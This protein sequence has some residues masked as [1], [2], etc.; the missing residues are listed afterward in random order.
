MV[1]LFVSL[2]CCEGLFS[3]F[4]CNDKRNTCVAFTD[5][6]GN[7]LKHAFSSGSTG[8]GE[9]VVAILGDTTRIVS[10]DPKPVGV[11][12]SHTLNL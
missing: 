12:P 1:F 4:H 5:A 9:S 3:S 8:I 6:V 2:Y 11:R 7:F 10:D